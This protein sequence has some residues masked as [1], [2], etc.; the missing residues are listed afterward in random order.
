LIR[1]SKLLFLDEATSSVDFETDAFIQK[2]IREEFKDCTVLTIAHRLDT[3]M[4]ADKI[5]VMEGGKVGEYNSPKSLL[6]REDSLFSQLVKAD[7]QES[8]KVS[9][10]D[11]VTV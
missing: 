2:T 5:L 11:D 1:K 9:K 8:Y 4:D 7:V 6:L 3:I 10:N